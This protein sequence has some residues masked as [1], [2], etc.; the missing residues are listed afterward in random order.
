MSTINVHSDYYTDEPIV[1]TLLHE[2]LLPSWTSSL[3]SLF[4]TFLAIHCNSNYH[5][6][7]CSIISH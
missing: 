3:S 6:H 4:K 2:I 1:Q 5:A 7:E